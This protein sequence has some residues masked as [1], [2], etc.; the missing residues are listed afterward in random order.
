MHNALAIPEIIHEIIDYLIPLGWEGSLTRERIN[1]DNWTTLDRKHLLSLALTCRLLR[2][3]ALEALWIEVPTLIPLL[4][5]LSNFSPQGS[6]NKYGFIDGPISSDDL[7][8]FNTYASR[9]RLCSSLLARVESSAFLKI[10]EANNTTFLLPKLYRLPIS[11][12]QWQDGLSFFVNP[13]LQSVDIYSLLPAATHASIT[14]DS[15][16]TLQ[17]KVQ[18]VDISVTGDFTGIIETPFHAARKLLLGSPILI[19]SSASFFIWRFSVRHWIPNPRL[20]NNLVE[21]RTTR[22]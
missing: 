22:V 21:S 8:R 2:G 1:F 10:L 18:L 7:K 11:P 4:K 5:L 16:L 20:S 6:P 19:R 9:I 14:L 12:I 13:N 17:R 3:P 15:I